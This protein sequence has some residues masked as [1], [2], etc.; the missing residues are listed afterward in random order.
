LGLAIAQG[1]V[2]ALNG[3]IWVESIGHDEVNYS[4]STFFLRLPVVK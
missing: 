2:K 3:N 1:I 4:G